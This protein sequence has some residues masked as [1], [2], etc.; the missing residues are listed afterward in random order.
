M[1]KELL[2]TYFRGE[3]TPEEEKQIMDWAES[4]PEN[5]QEYLKERKIWNAILM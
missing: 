3:A 2:H 1:D 4:S 5:Y